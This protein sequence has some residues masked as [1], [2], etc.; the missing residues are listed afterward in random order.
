MNTRKD[1][2]EP[3]TRLQQRQDA[4]GGKHYWRSLEELADSPA[5]RELLQQ[6]FP[7]QASQWDNA[8][9]RRQ[10]LTLMG[11]SLALAG[12]SGCSVKPAPAG[13]IVPYVRAPEEVSHVSQSGNHNRFNRMQTVLRL[14]EDEGCARLEDFVGDF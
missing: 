2:A 7:E 5:F 8:L 14:I 3:W 4:G 9:S 6:E 11:A 13:K 12:V 1:L 10:F